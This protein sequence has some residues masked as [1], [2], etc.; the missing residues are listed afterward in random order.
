MNHESPHNQSMYLTAVQKENMLVFK[1]ASDKNIGSMIFDNNICKFRFMQR[2]LFIG[3]ALEGKGKWQVMEF[4]RVVYTTA[5][6]NLVGEVTLFPLNCKITGAGGWRGGTRLVDDDGSVLLT[7]KARGWFIPKGIYDINME[8]VADIVW[9][10]IT[11][12]HHL[13]GSRAKTG[14]LTVNFG[15]F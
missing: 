8:K 5:V 4:G 13:L 1:D 3:P 6:N 14:V 10:F 12:Y 2:N 7:I 11:M 9:V 15:L